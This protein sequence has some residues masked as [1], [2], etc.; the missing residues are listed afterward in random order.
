MAT[1]TRPTRVLV[2]VIRA[3]AARSSRRVRAQMSPS[4]VTAK[5]AG[6]WVGLACI[7]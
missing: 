1:A 3:M 7:K 6:S 4:H 5:D 2:E